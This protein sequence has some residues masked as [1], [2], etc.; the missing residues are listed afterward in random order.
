M[1]MPSTLRPA[2]AL[3]ALALL[4]FAGPA[5]RAELVTLDLQCRESFAGGMAFGDIGPYEKIVGV[6]RFA[7]DPAHARNQLIV[8]LARERHRSNHR[9]QL[10]PEDLPR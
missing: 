3:A 1:R 10:S 4:L 2:R 8:D 7:V 5:G 9:P 6:A